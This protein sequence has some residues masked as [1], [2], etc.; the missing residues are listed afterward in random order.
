MKIGKAASRE[1]LK[2]TWDMMACALMMCEPQ[3]GPEVEP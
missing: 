1:M 3:V 2:E